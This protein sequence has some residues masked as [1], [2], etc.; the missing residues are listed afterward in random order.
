MEGCL[1]PVG[2]LRAIGLVVLFGLGDRDVLRHELGLVLGLVLHLGLR[3]VLGHEFGIVD[4]IVLGLSHILGLVGGF[5]D[6]FGQVN[7]VGDILG[8]V[9]G[10]VLIL[11]DVLHVCFVHSLRDVLGDVL[12][13]VLCVVLSVVLCIV[14]GCGNVVILV[15]SLVHRNLEE[16]ICKLRLIRRDE[17]V[18]LILGLFVVSYLEAVRL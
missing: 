4:G 5:C 9:N 6:V 14:E 13:I 8:L 10:V 3:Q 17:Q 11:G 7:R 18:I 16:G 1:R 2:R 15:H 12:G